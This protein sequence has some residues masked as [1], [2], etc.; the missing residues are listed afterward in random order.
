MIRKYEWESLHERVSKLEK[1]LV[2]QERS[3]DFLLGKGFPMDC[4][5][6]PD[7]GFL[8]SLAK[9]VGICTDCYKGDWRV[10]LVN[11]IKK[12]IKERWNIK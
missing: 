1:C 6:T 11:D 7:Y 12:K 4:W 5:G 3:I 9:K 10:E 2:L 8:G